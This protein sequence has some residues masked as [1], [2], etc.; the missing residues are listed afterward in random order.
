MAAAVAARADRSR[1]EPT[2]S[3]RGRSA[4]TSLSANGCK[5]WSTRS[6]LTRRPGPAPLSAGP[7]LGLSGP[8]GN[9]MWPWWLPTETSTA[10]PITSHSRSSRQARATQCSPS[11]SSWLRLQPGNHAVPRSDETAARLREF[12]ARPGPDYG[13][14]LRQEG[15]PVRRPRPPDL[16]ARPD[17]TPRG[18]RR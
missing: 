15:M 17:L 7:T 10:Y 12:A 13:E 11:G 1:V 16:P 14:L 18:P 2:R 5:P 4:R 9:G 3:R 6:P 8:R